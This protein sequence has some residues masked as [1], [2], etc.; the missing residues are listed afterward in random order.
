MSDIKTTF[1]P[2]TQTFDWTLVGGQL[3]MDDGPQTGVILS[4]FTDRRAEVD[5]VLPGGGDD[6]RGWW[7]DS[8]PEV[9]GDQIGSRLWLLA[10]SK[11]TAAVLSRAREYGAEALRWMRE[12][13]IAQRVD[14]DAERVMP[15]M[16]GLRL[17]IIKPDRSRLDYRFANLWESL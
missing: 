17:A 5:D 14:V 7:G 2:D 8:Y 6:R 16:L 9:P 13:G 4:V 11:D 3:A 15:G 10:R 12:D 1:N